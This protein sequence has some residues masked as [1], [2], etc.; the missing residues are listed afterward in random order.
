M[1]RLNT[2]LIIISLL[3]GV[4]I[5]YNA[6]KTNNNIP[7]IKTVNKT[8]NSQ[9]NYSQ[10]EFYDNM[11]KNVDTIQVYETNELTPQIMAN[12]N[13][14]I[15]VEKIIGQVTNDNL[16]GKILNCDINNGGYTNKD[17][18][19]YI[20]YERVNGAKK[21]DK[22]LTYYIYNPF[23]NEQDDVLTRMDFIIDCNAI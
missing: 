17:G 1:K 11:I 19:N 4:F 3:V 14:K 10:V 6:P 23:T 16:D 9:Y 20:N 8:E 12:R 18:G 15:I 5:G 22:V 2:I 21:G 13:G 7:N